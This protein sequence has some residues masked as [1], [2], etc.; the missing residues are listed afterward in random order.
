[1]K[2]IKISQRAILGDFDIIFYKERKLEMDTK[3]KNELRKRIVYFS[4]EGKTAITDYTADGLVV[5]GVGYGDPT[6]SGLDESMVRED[7]FIY[8]G[9]DSAPYKFAI[10]RCNDF[11]RTWQDVAKLCE[12]GCRSVVVCYSGV[13]LPPVDDEVI[14]GLAE[15]SDCG[16]KLFV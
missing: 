7:D 3:N 15:H 13:T 1:M 14:K 16:W 10:Y 5:C 2:V 12:M 6:H 4:K 9:D 11:A 8:K